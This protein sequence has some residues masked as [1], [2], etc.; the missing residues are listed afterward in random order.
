MAAYRDASGKYFSSAASLPPILFV[1]R[2]SEAG[3]KERTQV[4]A[5]CGG[6]YFSGGFTSTWA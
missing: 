1:A 3:M 4:L 2:M 6:S 5:E